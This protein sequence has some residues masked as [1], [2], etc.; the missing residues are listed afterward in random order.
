MDVLLVYVVISKQLAY[1]YVAEALG[2]DLSSE[3][4]DYQDLF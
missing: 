1:D 4:A 2:K 3:Q